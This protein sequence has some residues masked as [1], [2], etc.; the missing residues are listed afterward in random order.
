[1]IQNQKCYYSFT[2]QHSRTVNVDG[3]LIGIRDSHCN[4]SVKFKCRHN[5]TTDSYH[6]TAYSNAQ[7]LQPSSNDS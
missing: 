6:P 5:T 1:M 4:N 3:N 2:D 7:E